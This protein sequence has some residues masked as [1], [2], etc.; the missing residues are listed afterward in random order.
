MSPFLQIHNIKEWF[1]LSLYIPMSLFL[2]LFNFIQR[3][4]YCTMYIFSALKHKVVLASHCSPKFAF[5]LSAVSNQAEIALF[6]LFLKY[7][8]YFEKF[9]KT[10]EKLK[11]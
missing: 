4:M 2:L 1:H 10:R 9:Y 7:F 6:L 11:F 8:K 3:P 5:Q